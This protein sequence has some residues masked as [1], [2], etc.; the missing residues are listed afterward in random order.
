MRFNLRLAVPVDENIN[1]EGGKWFVINFLPLLSIVCVTSVTLLTLLFC[2]L[3]HV[4][5]VFSIRHC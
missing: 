4:L 3:V 5:S 1:R 2:F